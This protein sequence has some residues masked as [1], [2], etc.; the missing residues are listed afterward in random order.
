MMALMI[1]RFY[2]GWI[3]WWGR[4]GETDAIGWGGGGAGLGGGRRAAGRM[5]G[6]GRRVPWRRKKWPPPRH[7]FFLFF[8]LFFF[9][10]SSA[11]VCVFAVTP[12]IAS[13]Q[14]TGSFLLVSRHS[15][16]LCPV[17]YCIRSFF[18]S[19]A[20]SLSL[21]LSLVLAPSLIAANRV[22][23]RPRRLIS[24]TSPSRGLWDLFSNPGRCYRVFLLFFLSFFLSFFLFLKRSV[25]VNVSA[26]H[27]R[28]FLRS[29]R[30]W[31]LP[32]AHSS[33]TE[34]YRVLPSFTEFYRVLPRL[35]FLSLSSNGIS[36]LGIWDPIAM[37]FLSDQGG[38]LSDWNCLSDRFKKKRKA[39]K[40]DRH[41]ARIP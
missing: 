27:Y 22:S 37:R 11:F 13:Q 33:V 25:A 24:T 28:V 4:E 14:A 29:N 2:L 21:S 5:E 15:L 17:L 16:S 34:F 8:Y 23:L 35:I 19:F 7:R 38:P 6:N 1:G 3:Y 39:K 26:L 10:S 32:L 9:C 20:L 12:S 40:I 31:P 41:A 18:L 30:P 36:E